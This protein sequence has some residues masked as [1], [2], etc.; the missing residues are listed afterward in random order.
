[1]NAPGPRVPL[2]SIA[3]FALL[4]TA[5]LAALILLAVG[6]IVQLACAVVLVLVLV[7]W[8]RRLRSA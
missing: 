5:C 2:W 4:L 8:I 1:M 3:V 7:A 6:W